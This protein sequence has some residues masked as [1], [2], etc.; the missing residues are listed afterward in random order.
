MMEPILDEIA[1]EFEERRV[2]V[3]K[4]GAEQARDRGPVQDP[5]HP[6]PDPLRDG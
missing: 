6:H 3:A 4:L 2:T 1:L 5:L